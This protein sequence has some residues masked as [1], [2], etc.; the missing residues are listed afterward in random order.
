MFLG[1]AMICCC[2]VLLPKPTI[3]NNI[4]LLFLVWRKELALCLPVPG[5]EGPTGWIFSLEVPRKKDLIRSVLPLTTGSS[6]S[7]LQ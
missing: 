2:Y 4:I 5:E 1:F 6:L 7:S 3:G